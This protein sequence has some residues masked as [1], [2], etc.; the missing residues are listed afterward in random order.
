MGEGLGPAALTRPLLQRVL[1]LELDVG[2]DLLLG[3]RSEVD[4]THGVPGLLDPFL[5]IAAPRDALVAE[6]I[7]AVTAG[8]KAGALET[9]A[10]AADLC[11]TS[12][13][14]LREAAGVYAWNNSALVFSARTERCLFT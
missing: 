4:R 11:R 6:G 1:V 5:G 13:A 7:R 3:R 14:P 2:I 8:D 9:F 10:S 12:S